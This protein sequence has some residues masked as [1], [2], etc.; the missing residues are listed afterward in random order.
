M[1]QRY[2]KARPRNVVYSNAHSAWRAAH[3][4]NALRFALS[5]LRPDGHFPI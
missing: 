2:A 1:P 5:A 4:R 3:I